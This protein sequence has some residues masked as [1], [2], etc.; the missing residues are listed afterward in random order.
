[1]ATLMLCTYLWQKQGQEGCWDHWSLQP[2]SEQQHEEG[3]CCPVQQVL[4]QLLR[5][6]Q[7]PP[8]ALHVLPAGIE[9]RSE[10]ICQ[11]SNEAVAAHCVEVSPVPKRC[12]DSCTSSKLQEAS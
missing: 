5:P 9:C 3:P 10:R 8:L 1:M 11:D 4:W 2:L 6:W 7:A 12:T